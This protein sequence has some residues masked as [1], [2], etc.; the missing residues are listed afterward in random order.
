[1]NAELLVDLVTTGEDGCSC[2]VMTEIGEAD[3]VAGCIADEAEL[4]A[5]SIRRA[6]RLT[7]V[8]RVP[9]PTVSRD[10]EGGH[11]H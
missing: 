7:F 8:V 11:T 1:M 5:S 3:G 6:G 9:P 4:P 2:N 10:R